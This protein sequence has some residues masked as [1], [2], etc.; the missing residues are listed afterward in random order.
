MTIS[1]GRVRARRGC[2]LRYL[3]GTHGG[4]QLAAARLELDDLLSVC[5]Y[6]PGTQWGTRRGT[7]SVTARGTIRGTVGV[8]QEYC[9]GYWKGY[10]KA[11]CKGY[12]RGTH[13]VR[14]ARRRPHAWSPLRRRRSRSG[15]KSSNSSGCAAH[16]QYSR[17]THGVLTGYS[18]GT[19]FGSGCQPPWH[20]RAPRPSAPARRL[21]LPRHPRGAHAVLTAGG[22]CGIRTEYSR[23]TL[24]VLTACSRG[25]CGRPGL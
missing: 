20:K 11:Y 1:Y 7:I 3:W 2:S 17:G 25:A 23:G 22:R 24:R 21:V 10:S 14:P 8:L 12:S 9:M 6:T 15:W 5:P 18:R 4:V 16:P 13:G 19:H